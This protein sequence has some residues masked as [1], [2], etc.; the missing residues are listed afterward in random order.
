MR[1]GGFSHVGRC[2]ANFHS[3]IQGESRVQKREI[4]EK[5][6]VEIGKLKKFYFAFLMI[7]A[8]P[9]KF[10][11]SKNR[12]D[13]RGKSPLEARKSETNTPTSVWRPQGRRQSTN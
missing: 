4:E 7:R 12:W 8:N 1:N 6:H 2:R 3:Q 9:K 11:G 10:S 13:F 5:A